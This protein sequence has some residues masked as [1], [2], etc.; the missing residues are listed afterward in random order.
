[1]LTAVKGHSERA[2]DVQ[3]GAEKSQTGSA[4]ILENTG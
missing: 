3:L 2:A 1:M 4:G